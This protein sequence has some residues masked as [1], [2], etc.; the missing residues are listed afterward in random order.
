[1]KMDGCIMGTHLGIQKGHVGLFLHLTL[2][3][4]PMICHLHFSSTDI[5]H[6]IFNNIFLV[7]CHGVSAMLF[8]EELTVDVNVHQVFDPFHY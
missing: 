4:H 6:K 5:K 1:L 8:S 7:P 3:G 2:R